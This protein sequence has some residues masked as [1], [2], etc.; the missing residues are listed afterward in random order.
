M[1]VLFLCVLFLGSFCGQAANA[2]PKMESAK[3][4]SAR[5]TEIAGYYFRPSGD[6]PFPAVV[7]MHGCGGLFEE[8]RR[9]LSPNRMDWAQ[10]FRE[11]RLR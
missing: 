11:C 9:T 1:R 3:F 7:G 2:A 8:D 4:P 5:G 6:G 10:R